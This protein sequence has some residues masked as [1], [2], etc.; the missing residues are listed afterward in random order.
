MSIDELETDLT[1]YTLRPIQ[2]V[3]GGVS[4]LE[5]LQKFPGNFKISADD[6]ARFCSYDLYLPPP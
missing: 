1:T 6:K 3:T 4:L 5:F 2:A